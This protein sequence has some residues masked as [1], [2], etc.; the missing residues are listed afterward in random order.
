MDILHSTKTIPHAYR[1]DKRG[2]MSTSYIVGAVA[3]PRPESHYTSPT[4]LQ[5]VA[6]SGS[7]AK[8]QA[9]ELL[10]YLPLS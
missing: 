4:I 7:S 5:L 3:Y 1:K 2:R 10:K 6:F 8:F 9:E